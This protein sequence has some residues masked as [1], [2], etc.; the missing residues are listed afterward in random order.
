MRRDSSTWVAY[1]LITWVSL[2]GLHYATDRHEQ[3][4]PQSYTT[5]AFRNKETLTAMR[6]LYANAIAEKMEQI[7]EAGPLSTIETVHRNLMKQFSDKSLSPADAAL[8]SHIGKVVQ[9]ELIALSTHT[10][11]WEF[12]QILAVYPYVDETQPLWE[13]SNPE[14]IQKR[15]ST[16]RNFAQKMLLEG[17]KS[18]ARQ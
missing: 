2:F 13:K 4:P 16:Y 9:E 17:L 12:S 8:S 15:V 3:Q 11:R 6:R 7:P 10:T 1:A 18:H 5:E 14:D